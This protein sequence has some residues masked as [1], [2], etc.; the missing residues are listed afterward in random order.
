MAEQA[1]LK[2][3][4]VLMNQ[5]GEAASSLRS[6]PEERAW[7]A[8]AQQGEIAAFDWL[9]VRYRTRALRLAAHVL[10]TPADAEDVVQEAFLRAFAQ[11]RSFRANC[12]F[13]TWLYRIIVRLCL[14]HMR[15]RDWQS[16]SLSLSKE[17]EVEKAFA[18]PPPSETRLMIEDLLERLSPPLRAALILRELEGLD[19]EEIAETLEIPVGTVRS[20]LN[21]AR[22][23]FQTLWLKAQ[24]ESNHV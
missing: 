17:Q 7:I 2:N 15:T 11:I 8:R 10:R 19:Y 14:N 5:S 22:Y 13:Y 24:E 20:R 16:G 9:M 23:Q 6:D 3:G 12:T 1:A 18:L 21:A 4:V